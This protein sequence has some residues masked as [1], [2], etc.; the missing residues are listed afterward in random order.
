VNAGRNS[1][2]FAG[3]L[4]KSHLSA[5]ELFVSDDDRKSSGGA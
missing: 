1:H 4:I 5:F 3:I 2:F